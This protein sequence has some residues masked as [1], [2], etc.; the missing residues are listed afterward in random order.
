MVPPITRQRRGVGGRPG[1]LPQQQSTN[2]RAAEGEDPPHRS[3]PQS[4]R[5]SATL[6]A[7]APPTRCTWEPVWG[8]RSP[9]PTCAGLKEGFCPENMSKKCVDCVIL[10]VITIY[11]ENTNQTLGKNQQQKFLIQTSVKVL[12]QQLKSLS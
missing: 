10:Q 2:R 6:R 7:L 9:P 5:L 11:G 12:K 1:L 3:H 8:G 4:G